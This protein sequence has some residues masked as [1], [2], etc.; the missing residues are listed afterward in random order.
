MS[1][2]LW[3]SGLMMGLAGGPHCLAMCGAACSAVSMRCG[4]ARSQ[5]ALGAW[6]AG[7]LVSYS[8]AGAL[9]ASSVSLLGEWGRELAWLRPWWVMLHL[10]AMA[11]GLWMLWQ[12][13]TPQWMSASVRLPA[14]AAGEAAGAT[15]DA[16]GGLVLATA[17]PGH[18]RGGVASEV[19]GAAAQRPVLWLRASG[20]G[21]AWVALP[22]GLL[23]SALVVAALGSSAA[24]GALVMAAFAIGS[25]VSLWFGPR[26]WTWL[27]RAGRGRTDGW[28]GPV[29]A[30]RLAGALLAIGSGWAVVHHVLMPW[31]TAF[32][33]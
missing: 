4:G 24:E 28:L 1:A 18:G 8:L 33:A 25:G 11:L 30:V 19:G 22:C 27:A 20:A 9:V 16:G 21:A 6:Q 12:G 26:L 15:P 13:R 23:Q 14:W 7:R 2:W 3:A 17:L 32:C 5:Q 31:W 10:A 29:Q